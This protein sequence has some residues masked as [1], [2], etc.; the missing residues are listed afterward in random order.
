[1]A[2]K[3]HKRCAACLSLPIS[4]PVLAGW[5]HM[6]HGSRLTAH[7]SPRYG[8]YTVSTGACAMAHTCSMYTMAMG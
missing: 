1:M 3:G 2:M 8:A 7:G 6:A 5:V 4:C